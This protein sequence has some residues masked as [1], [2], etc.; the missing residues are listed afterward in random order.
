MSDQSA[1]EL[2]LKDLQDA[3]AF[4]AAFRS[5][6]R[7]Q[8]AGGEGDKVFP[9]TFAGA[10]YAIEQRRIP[11]C[12]ESVHCVLLD[13]V[14]SQANRMEQALQDAVDAKM[15][16]IPLIEV[17]FTKHD[18]TGDLEADRGAGRLVDAVGK[19]T[20]LQVPHRLADAILR[21]SDVEEERDGKSERIAFRKSEI[22]RALNTVS[23]ANATPLFELCPTALI[24]GMWDSTGPKGGLGP[25]FERA[26][27]SEIVGVGVEVGDLRR[28]VRRDPLEVRAAVKVAKAADRSWSLAAGSRGAVSPSEVNHSSVP[29]PKQRGEKTDDNYYDGATIEYAEQTTTLS[30][31]CLRRLCFPIDGKSNIEA[32]S[33][34]RVVLATLGL[35]GAALAFEAGLGLRSRCLLWPDGPME[36]ELLEKPGTPPKRFSL[37]GEQAVALL[38]KAVDAAKKLKLPWR[39]EPLLLKPSVGKGR[40]ENLVE[41]VRLSQLEATKEGPDQES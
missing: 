37:T 21:D 18:P 7:L 20:S 31:I 17:D 23:L 15:L 38:T 4:A 6:R 28:G 35:C 11:G 14:Q 2:T 8:P 19:V 9:P 41:L 22:G 24:F 39:E 26:I 1:K 34:A 29:F 10:V 30:L 12:A 40:T 36:W 27:V 25:K 3:V 32:D 33:A 16:S 13:S 5:R